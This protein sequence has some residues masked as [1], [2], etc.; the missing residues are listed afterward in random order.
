MQYLFIN[1]GHNVNVCSHYKFVVVNDNLHILMKSYYV[2]CHTTAYTLNTSL[3]PNLG[4]H[5]C[6][7]IYLF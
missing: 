3:V 1:L 6:V 7:S 4:D 5:L 2:Q